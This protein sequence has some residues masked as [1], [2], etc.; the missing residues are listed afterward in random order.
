[1]G[2]EIERKFLLSDERWRADVGNSLRLC[3]G[4]LT[5]A[6]ALVAGLARC[7]VRVRIAGDE[8]WLN[9]KSA[10]L[11]VRR[12]EFEYPLPLSDAEHMLDRLCDGRVEKIRHFVRV[13]GHRFEID[14]FLGDNAGLVVAELELP[15]IDAAFPRPPWLGREVSHVSRY[16]NVN[17]VSHPWR[18]WNAAERAGEDVACS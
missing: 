14:E 5:D 2:V 9:I 4:Y 10:E 8:A 3:Q 7:S 12:L 1:M 13:Q 18:N 17:L 6:S 15:A 16:Y 11:G